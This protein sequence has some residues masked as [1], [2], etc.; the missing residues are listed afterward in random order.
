M[1]DS[2]RP[3]QLEFPGFSEL[4]KQID[5]GSGQLSF[6]SDSKSEDRIIIESPNVK[7]LEDMMLRKN[8]LKPKK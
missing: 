2:S 5:D 8:G 6:F 1:N 3:V 7:E 4:Y